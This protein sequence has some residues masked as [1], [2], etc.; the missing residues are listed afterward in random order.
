MPEKP[1]E[2]PNNE[3]FLSKNEQFLSKNGV[4]DSDPRLTQLR[5]D[6]EQI[7]ASYDTATD[8]WRKRMAGPHLHQLLTNQEETLTF[9]RHPDP[10]LRQVALHLAVHHWGLGAIVATHCEKMAVT[11][12]DSD[13]RAM[14]ISAL[15]SCYKNSQDPRVG[16]F[17]ATLIRDEGTATETRKLAYASLITIHGRGRDRYTPLFPRNFP[18][19]VDWEFVD[20]YYARGRE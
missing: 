3:Q 1:E 7:V 15:A 11:D 18:E 10:S 9:L 12:P 8:E 2:E 5:K 20:D 14:A 16:N 4:A 17:L 6:F 13:V 19:D